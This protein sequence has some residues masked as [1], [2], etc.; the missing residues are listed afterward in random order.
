MTH[1]EHS[2][3]TPRR[4]S[5]IFAALG[6]CL[7]FVGGR[8]PS[9]RSATVACG[10]VVGLCGGV[11]VVVVGMLPVA[12][13][14]A[15]GLPFFQPPPKP[16]RTYSTRAHVELTL[17]PRGLATEWEAEYAPAGPS[18]E[19]PMKEAGC[20]WV[21]VNKATISTGLGSSEDI[22][23]GSSDPERGKG[24]E[25]VYLRHLSPETSYYARFTAK[26]EE[27]KATETVSFKT[28]P[29]GKPEIPVRYN[30]GETLLF[31]GGAT[32]DTTAEFA[33]KVET[34][35]SETEYHVEYALPEG[36]HA[37]AS[38]SASWKPFTSGASGTITPGEEYAQI[39]AQLTG[40]APETTYYV[41]VKASNKVG[42]LIQTTFEGEGEGGKTSTFKTF[43]AK[44]GAETPTVRNVTAASAHLVADVVPHGSK[45]V[46]RLEF[47]S[48][49][50]GPWT[51]VP[52]GSSSLS[53]AQAE[54]TPY[55]DGHSSGVRLEGLAPSKVYYVR[56]VAEN[57]CE[58]G[59]GSATSQVESFETS[60]APSATVLAV[61][62]LEGES[63]RLLGAVN[64]NSLA[65]SAEQS[66]AIE[67]APTG[68]TFNL[69]FK[70]QSTGGTVT[71]T[72]ANGSSTVSAVPL[73]PV[74][75][76]GNIVPAPGGGAEVV[77]LATS[78]GHF[79]I[80]EVISGEGLP[81]GTII[82]AV[83]GSTLKLSAR[84]TEAVVGAALT[85]AGPIPFTAGEEITGAGI[86]A[87]TTVT[88]FAYAA[89]RTGTLTLSAAAQASG[90]GVE[91]TAGLPYSATA[92][93][94][95]A[96]L[97]GLPE[98][99]KVGVEG[100]AGGPYTV[101]FHGADGEVAEPTIEGDG[102]GL[103]PPGAVKVEVTQQGGVAYDTHY[104]FEYVS[105]KSF[106]EHGWADAAQT[107]EVDAG[108]GVS[109]EYVGAD[110]PALT[111]GETYRYRIVAHN[112]APGTGLVESGEQ[113]LIVPVPAATESTGACLNE[114]FRSGLSAHLPDCR[115][116]EILTPPDKHGS[117][118]LWNYGS[119]TID[120]D[121]LVGED[122]EHAVLESAG[123]DWGTG[124][125]FGNSPYFFSRVMGQGWSLAEGSPEP[126]TGVYTNYPQ[127]YNADLTQIAFVSQYVISAAGESPDFEY[128]VGPAG[129][130][131]RTVA[132]VP[133]QDVPGRTTTQAGWV[134]GTGDFSKLVLAT[135]DRT[136][137][138]EESTGTKSGTDLYEYTA[139]GGL[140]QLNVDGEG[141]TIGSCGAVVAHGV[142]EGAQQHLHSGP[143]SIS[144]D[145][146]RVFFEATPGRNCSGPSHLY[147]RVNGTDT[148]DIGAY[149]FLA[150]DSQG[151]RV[152]LQANGEV[153]LYDTE[154]ASVK[155]LFDGL[156]QGSL[157]V[158]ADFT[159]VYA[160]VGGSLYR[161][162]ISS[163]RL[164]FL[165][166][167]AVIGA[168]Y[169]SPDGRYYY[170]DGGVAGVPGGE[171]PQAYR[172]DSAE[173]VVECVSCVSGFDPQPKQ[174]AFLDGITGTQV[175]EGGLPNYTPISG[176]GDF[177]FFT[178]PAALVP[179]DIDGELA[180]ARTGSKEYE[181][182]GTTSPSSDVYEWRR[183]G[184]DGCSQLQGCLA[185]ITD[186]RGGY[187]NLLL[188]T[189]DEGR[190]VFIYTRSQLT[191]Q[192]NDTSGDIYDVRIDGGFTPPPPRPVE[193]EGDACS[194]PPSAPSDATP[195]SLTFNG[196]GNLA[197]EVT[198]VSKA[199]K[200]KPKKA[201][202][203][204]KRSKRKSGRRKRAPKSSERR[205]R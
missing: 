97:E 152:L 2:P 143:H 9:R 78:A 161:Y 191:A 103:A 180:P 39:E 58:V 145:G 43:T 121:L 91:L 118:E 36:G 94:V 55:E 32:S 98:E 164:S 33:V 149:Q 205:A 90:S 71:G 107:P 176:N 112:T 134:A 92:E 15:S 166:Q 67:G 72:L 28:L 198:P 170:F 171:G 64:P 6:A 37:P 130:P 204:K 34:N 137:F 115:A 54:A 45:T 10:T 5:A 74:S 163:E 138:G 190:D 122:G 79:H 86:S 81:P 108:S 8:A 65:T 142:E 201:K 133:S 83:E 93:V 40:L 84:P 102:L 162:D 7:R 18:C 160:E 14:L 140:R 47:A 189:A 147:M 31:G 183:D 59:C 114:A 44:P 178:T 202:P 4:G 82:T 63:S 77:D 23:L 26:N 12:P 52:G 73:P 126:E 96:A 196:A 175:V 88:G 181:D 1:I 128:K 135:E 165:M 95:I 3:R 131:Y 22:F 105:Q 155:H 141:V 156:T 203:K 75:G 104:H 21:A 46:W 185:L 184:V 136:L 123:V 62:A 177:A 182:I 101:H 17:N 167:V 85:A 168:G 124:P 193:C 187:K 11:V 61:H 159:A 35:G 132:M 20:A 25:D 30:S 51:R 100:S 179:Q 53:Q 111:P 200:L 70:G 144:A 172:Y 110:L 197:A 69:T 199:T 117:Q 56:T 42:E 49:A 76:T 50:S 146:S 154:T 113:T 41:R 106:A 186:G 188:G 158:S 194:S 125:G 66:I 151:S 19:P 139:G 173:D 68:G 153:F 27:G 192:D 13:A 169:T 119:L 80:G 87:G 29:L 89:D 150:A 127:V 157:V 174:P 24:A 99:P 16:D 195:S 129:G 148:I 57:E 60:G 48:E 109:Q 116:Y 38:G 120:T